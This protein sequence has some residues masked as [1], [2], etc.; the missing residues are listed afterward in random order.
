MSRNFE[1]LQRLQNYDVPLV[2][3]DTASSPVA[4]LA[5]AAPRAAVFDRRRLE[6]I[7]GVSPEIFKLVHNVFMPVEAPPRVVA[8]SRVGEEPERDF[9]GPQV[10]EVLAAQISGSVCVVDANLRAPYLHSYFQI[11]NRNGLAEALTRHELMEKFT[12]HV[13]NTHVWVVTGGAAVSDGEAALSSEAMRSRIS[14]LRSTFDHVLVCAPPVLGHPETVGIARLSDGL[15][16]I[17]EA[18]ATRRELALRAKQEMDQA[19]VRLLGAALNNRRFPIPQALY[20][21]L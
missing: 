19:G 11:E 12:H 13:E 21:M 15:I 9:I 1:L 18:N 16:L 6:S 8:F 5:A 14:E 4:P 17:V 20:A 10:A 3:A 2:N 7:K